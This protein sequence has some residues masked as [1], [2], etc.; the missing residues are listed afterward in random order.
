[1][2][3]VFDPSDKPRLF[4]LAPGV[5]FARAFAD[6]LMRRLADHPPDL[7]ARTS[8]FF[9][10]RR[11]QEAVR[12]ALTANGAR[13]LPRLRLVTDLASDPLPGIPPAVPKLRRTLEVMRLVEALIAR[14]PQIAPATAAFGLAEDLVAL[15]AEMQD[16]SVPPGRLEDLTLAED[17]AE[18]WQRSLE[19][20]R[21]ATGFTGA[22]AAKD[23]DGRQ[24]IAIARLIADWQANGQATPIIVAGSTGSRG[25]TLR[26]MLAVASLPQGAVVLPGYDYDLPPTVWATLS[27]ADQ[28]SEDHPQ[29]RF[30]ALRLALGPALADIP[31]W[32]EGFAAP[33]PARNRLI[34]LALRPAPMT[35]DWLRDGPALGDARAAALGLS[36]IE[37]NGPVEEAQAVALCL[38]K[39][40][41]D[42]RRVALITPDRTLARR[43]AAM[44]DRWGIIP[45]DSAGEPLSQTPPG[46][47]LRHIAGLF[48][49]P[50][51]SEVLLIVL[52]HPLTASAA[53]E[54]GPHLRLTRELEL[55]LRRH[56]P[57]FPTANDI[58]AWGDMRE[59]H[60]WANWLAGCLDGIPSGS[61]FSLSAWTETLLFVADR[62]AAGPDATGQHR[63]WDGKSG[64]ALRRALDELAA[65]ATVGGI[66]T[67]PVFQSVLLA[68]LAA[69]PVR[70]TV[71]ADPRVAIWGT[72][73]SRVQGA[74]L[75]V[76][77][78][79]NEGT[80]PEPPPPDPW[81]SRQM[82]RR[83]GLLSPERRIGLSAHD[84]Q[85][86]ACAAE[87]VL[88]RS[89]RNDGTDT[90]P[91]RWLLRLT[92]LLPGLTH[93]KDALTAMRL[94]G[95]VW[96]DLAQALHRPKGNPQPARR[97][98]PRPPVRARPTQLS[99][100]QIRTLI[101]DPYAIYAEKVLRLRPLDPLRAEPEPR[102]RGRVLHRV[103]QDLVA[104][105]DLRGDLLGLRERLLSETERRLNASVPWPVERRFWMMRMEA[106]AGPFL[107]NE[108]RRSAEGEPLFLEQSG[109]LE[110]SDDFVLTG[111]PDRI[112][113]MTDGKLHILD[114]K[115][116]GLPPAAAMFQDERQLP[117][118]AIMAE[119]GA[120]GGL[121]AEVGRLTYVHIA[122]DG[123]ERQVTPEDG[124]LADVWDDLIRL[125]ENYR[126]GGTGYVARARWKDT[127]Y[128][129]A[130][131][132]LSRLGEWQ[133]HDP[134][135]AGD[136]GGGD[137]GGG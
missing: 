127:R 136:V 21:I 37:A 128:E 89:V 29:Y 33:D 54:R 13:L 31:V 117:L 78:G 113:R 82:R 66:Q 79:L 45:D 122:A 16:E 77:A 107:M 115:T 108:L 81:M 93:G 42:G 59:E 60:G 135:D 102:L 98:A 137:G 49:T 72:L 28:P 120:F 34:S 44:L 46:R 134:A 80:W 129:G 105:P 47:F 112:D 73:E 62:F 131:D 121:H 11:M 35:D 130:Y 125:V 110:V 111:R 76:L 23:G 57:A 86:A 9:N 70:E 24:Q 36:L 50:L 85:Q 83:V 84:F 64:T 106:F 22:D 25:T 20:L 14:Q 32:S 119:A 75:V 19:F 38:R 43:V 51:T 91:S 10:T 126:D 58:R 53:G 40:T 52:K 18:H 133:L 1:M 103:V 27:D 69:V 92:N 71:A 26:L 114:Y 132:H 67:A 48:G 56:G 74:D 87:V 7:A 3:A 39:A 6:G 4:G 116:G 90:V 118:E 97:P 109:L 2:R 88:S 96:T 61:E 30:A 41:E 5:D 95:Q 8:V 104:L 65:E 68:H 12:S 63:L 101:R 17:H 124:K 100:T 94:R 15:L 99:V 55:T 123:Q